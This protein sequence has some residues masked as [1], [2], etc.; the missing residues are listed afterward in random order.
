[1]DKGGVV[2]GVFLDLRKAF[3]TDNHEILI[4]KLLK[5][6]VFPRCLEMDEILP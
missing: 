4:T 2:G 6:N 1:M 5:F 3:Y